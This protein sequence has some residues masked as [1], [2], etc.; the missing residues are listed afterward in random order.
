MRILEKTLC[1]L[2]LMCLWL[3]LRFNPAGELLFALSL[4]LLGIFYLF[5]SFALLH[6]I[7]FRKMFRRASYTDVAGKEIA[8]AIFWG[9]ILFI[10]CFAIL[11][12]GLRWG[13]GR[14]FS[15][16]SLFFLLPGVVISGTKMRH[17]NTAYYKRVFTRVLPMLCFC[18][19]FLTG[20]RKA[21][22]HFMYSD[23]PG[24]VKAV[25]DTWQHPRDEQAREM[26]QVEF[27][28]MKGRH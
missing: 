22:L 12:I 18:V 20:L 9:V 23:H 7:G 13:G 14:L 4:F 25:E 28:K 24:F 11:F 17:H 26:M 2:A 19:F 3:M 8:N 27:R 16:I 1:I 10:S 21:A 15:Y 6:G 5:F